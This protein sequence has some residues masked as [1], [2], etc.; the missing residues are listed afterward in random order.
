M[1]GSAPLG[2]GPFVVLTETGTPRHQPAR[3]AM[4]QLDLDDRL[5]VMFV[6][7]IALTGGV[8]TFAAIAYALVVTGSMEPSLDP[9]LVTML[10]PVLLVMMAG[11]VVLTRRMEGNIPADAGPEEKIIR[12]QTARIIGLAT[13]EG[14]ALMVIVLGMLAGA[15]AW[16]LAAGLLGVWSMFLAR[17]KRDD[18]EALLR[19]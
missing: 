2:A 17:P 12:Y 13:Q 7:W 1:K 14:P 18:L 8:L 9:S 3:Q 10:A 5:R 11:G 6:I 16:I 4:T 19:D 15:T